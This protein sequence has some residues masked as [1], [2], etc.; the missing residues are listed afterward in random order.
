M[1]SNVRIAVNI[2]KV[3]EQLGIVFGWA[4]VTE[5]DGQPVVDLQDDVIPTDVLEK[6]VYEFMLADRFDEMHEVA[7]RGHIV[8]SIVITDEKLAAMFPGQPLP[9][10]PRGWWIGVKPDPDV[11]EKFRR[12]QY[13]GFSIAGTAEKEV[14]QL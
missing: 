10:G 6:A 12:G 13:R 11:L 4:S 1:A 7:G 14:V 3:N 8:E 9:Q 2:A 5:I